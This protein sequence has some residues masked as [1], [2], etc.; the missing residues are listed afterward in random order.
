MREDYRAG[1]GGEAA[2]AL[3]GVLPAG[4]GAA[5]A[6]G[7]GT[8]QHRG[9]AYRMK[10]VLPVLYC[11]TSSTMGLFS[12]SASSRAGEWKSWKR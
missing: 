3:A 8:A 7:E 9:G 4:P 5:A 12:K 6:S 1:G 10:V 2:G 11:P